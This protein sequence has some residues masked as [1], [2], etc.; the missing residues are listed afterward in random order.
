MKDWI[1][2]H[3]NGVDGR[4]R[5]D[6]NRTHIGF[7][8][9]GIGYHWV[10]EENGACVAGRAMWR[11]GAHAKGFNAKSYGIVWI[12]NGNVHPPSTVQWCSLK[13]K[14]QELRYRGRGKRG[15]IPISR[16]IGH[17]EV[18]DFTTNPKYKTRKKCPGAEFDM[19][20]LR[21]ELELMDEMV[22]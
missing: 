15:P 7:G 13:A 19:Y 18:N 1:I 8:W 22:A 11:P 12:G 3:H 17:R 10:V 20:K 16:V 6:I 9:A 14:I 5:D 21:A 4:T 2:V